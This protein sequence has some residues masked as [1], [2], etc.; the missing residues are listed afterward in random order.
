MSG[1]QDSFVSSPVINMATENQKAT[2]KRIVENIGK[3]KKL[4]VSRVMRESGYSKASAKNPKILTQSKSWP[5]L[6]DQYFPE[7]DLA[8]I[9]SELLH[10]NV[11]AVLK[12]PL[13]FT[14]KQVKEVVAK[15]PGYE[16]VEIFDSLK[17]TYASCIASDADTRTRNLESALKLRGLFAPERF[18]IE[19]GDIKDM[20]DAELV[21]EEKRLDREVKSRKIDA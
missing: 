12:F 6:M 14:E 7:T 5:A 15:M 4:S 9:Q 2:V 1:E 17:A 13:G 16:I 8:Q 3:G 21:E 18:K 11:P 20:G 10:R 19:R